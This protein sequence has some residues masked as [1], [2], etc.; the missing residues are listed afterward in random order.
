MRLLSL[1]LTQFRSYGQLSLDLSSEGVHLLVGSN[2][3][4]KTNVLEAISIL[5]L[6]RSCLGTD[7]TDLTQWEKDFY[8]ISAKVQ[9]NNGEEKTLEVVSQQ[10]PRV[11]KA[12]FLNDVRMGIE[13][14]VGIMPTVVFLPQELQLFTGSPALRRRFVDRLLCQV[15]PEYLRALAQ[16]QK[17]LKQRNTLLRNIAEGRAQQD[18]LDIW[19]IHLADHGVPVTLARL[20][21]IGTLQLTLPEEIVALGESWEDI[22][23][24]YDRKGTECEA[25]ALKKEYLDTLL[26]NRKRDCILQATTAG[27]HREDWH[28]EVD[29]REIQSFASRGQQRASLL[30]LL[31]L[32]VSYLELRTGEKPIIL[33]DDV[34][35]E[36]DS[37]H[38][39]ALIHSLSGYQVIITTTY[40]PE[41][42][43]QANCWNVEEGSITTSKKAKVAAI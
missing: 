35:S 6:L 38:Q 5:S 27:P 42:E 40:I 13:S 32:Q 21:L 24:V 18:D 25:G 20:E 28:I 43:F 4:G 15:S 36:L 39:E 10:A 3:A 33:L 9:S 37:A 11:Q 16:Y 30:A 2:G 34:F 17:V 14:M 8:R 19:D 41:G 22:S 1:E 31:L 12:C 26:K 7:E 23:I 29:G